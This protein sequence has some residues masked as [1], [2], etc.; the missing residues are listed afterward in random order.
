M[1]LKGRNNMAKMIDQKLE[2]DQ[3]DMYASSLLSPNLTNGDIFQMARSLQ[4]DAVKQNVNLTNIVDFYFVLMDLKD[5][6]RSK[7]KRK[8][9]CSK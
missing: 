4:I 7:K 2:K 9:K 6:S 1:I 3:M 8:K 5:K